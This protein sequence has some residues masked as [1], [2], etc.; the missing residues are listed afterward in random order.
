MVVWV[1]AEENRGAQMRVPVWRLLRVGSPWRT[2]LLL[3][4]V[5]RGRGTV[6]LGI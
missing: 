2:P 6:M 1:S 5:L 4:R 3:A